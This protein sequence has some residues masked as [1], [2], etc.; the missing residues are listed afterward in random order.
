LYKS[1]SVR[2]LLLH[3]GDVDNELNLKTL[4]LK[5]CKPDGSYHQKALEV[6]KRKKEIHKFLCEQHP[7]DKSIP[8]K[9]VAEKKSGLDRKRKVVDRF[10]YSNS[11]TPSGEDIVVLMTDTRADK[12]HAT[13]TSLTPTHTKTNRQSKGRR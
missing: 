8:A 11:P 2:A 13:G 7:I 12:R 6:A 1:S 3:T 9:P 5:E 10:G 4:P